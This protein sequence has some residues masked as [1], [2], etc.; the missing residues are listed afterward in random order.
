MGTITNASCCAWIN[1]TGQRE[2]SI[3]KPEEKTTWHS[4]G[5]RGGLLIVY[6][7]CL[8]GCVQDTKSMVEGNTV[9]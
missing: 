3:W 9:D 6:G 7:M 4:A 1:A 2:R 8:A 5:G